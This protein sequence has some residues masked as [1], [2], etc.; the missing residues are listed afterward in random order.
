MYV[1]V[2]GVMGCWEGLG[3]FL[4]FNLKGR[5]IVAV[6]GLCIRT[7]PTTLLSF[8]RESELAQQSTNRTEVLTAA[9]AESLRA[10]LIPVRCCHR[11]HDGTTDQDERSA[12][13]LRL[14]PNGPPSSM[15][16]VYNFRYNIIYIQL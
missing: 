6:E 1:S 8:H 16:N 12:E 5:F 7:R 9:H 13:F 11:P 4:G 10:R 3:D 15:H 14:S 2:S